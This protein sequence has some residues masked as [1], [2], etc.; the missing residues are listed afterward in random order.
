MHTQQRIIFNKELITKY[1]LEHG[2]TQAELARRLD[3]SKNAISFWESGKRTPMPKSIDMLVESIGI[4][5]EQWYEIN[6]KTFGAKLTSMRLRNNI[7]Q[8]DLAKMIGTSS[9]N[10]NRW[11]ADRHVP[12]IFYIYQLSKVLNTTMEYLITD[13]KGNVL[14]TDPHSTIELD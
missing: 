7:A 3:V 9:E 4:P 2:I 10:I 5:H 13:S 6:D 11:E 1:R 14:V 12:S 8:N